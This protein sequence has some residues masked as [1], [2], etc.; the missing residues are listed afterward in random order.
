MISSMAKNTAMPNKTAKYN[1]IFQS[2]H[3]LRLHFRKQLKCDSKLAKQNDQYDSRNPAQCHNKNA[4]NVDCY[5]D[6]GQKVKQNQDNNP[7]YAVNHQPDNP[8]SELPHYNGQDGYQK[9]SQNRPK[10]QHF[11]HIKT[12]K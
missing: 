8:F 10:K 4:P 12:T 2:S 1:S 9:K 6:K 7:D 5:A 3:A 11:R